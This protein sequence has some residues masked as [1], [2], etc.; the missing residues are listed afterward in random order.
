MFWFSHIAA[1][2][3]VEIVVFFWFFFLS[4]SPIYFFIYLVDVVVFSI[5]DLYRTEISLT[6]SLI[7]INVIPYN[8]GTGS[9]GAQ[10]IKHASHK[11]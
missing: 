5:R 7:Y 6:C 3:S 2:S 4:S 11:M 9:T 10:E 1:H 8:P